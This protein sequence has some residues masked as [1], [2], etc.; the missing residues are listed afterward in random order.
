MGTMGIKF[1]EDAINTEMVTIIDVLANGNS[2][3]SKVGNNIVVEIRKEPN[4]GKE[5]IR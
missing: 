1:S 2:P 5:R 3:I 4:K